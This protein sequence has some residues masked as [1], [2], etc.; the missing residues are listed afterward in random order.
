M[1]AAMSNPWGQRVVHVWQHAHSQGVFE[2]RAMSSCPSWSAR[3]IW[4]G[5]Q[6]KNSTDRAAAGAFD[7]LVAQVDVLTQ[8]VLHAPGES[9]A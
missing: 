7:A 8:L 9:P 4:L 1:M 6:S 3:M 5:C 2:C